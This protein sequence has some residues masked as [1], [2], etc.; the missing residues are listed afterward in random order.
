MDDILVESDIKTLKFYP[1][2]KVNVQ[3]RIQLATMIMLAMFTCT[4]I[5]VLYQNRKYIRNF[6]RSG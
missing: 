3:S 1:K 4:Q 5:A 2:L 6:R